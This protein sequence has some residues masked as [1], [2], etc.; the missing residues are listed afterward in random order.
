MLFVPYLIRLPPVQQERSYP[1]MS[2]D[3]QQPPRRPR[4]G[5][6]PFNFDRIANVL[7]KM[8]QKQYGAGPVFYGPADVQ[9]PEDEEFID[10]EDTD[11]KR[12]E[13]NG[14]QKGPLKENPVLV[15]GGTGRTGLWTVLGLVNAGINVRVFTR[16]KK[17]AE[18]LFGPDGSNVDVFEGDMRKDVENGL[19]EALKGCWGVVMCAAGRWGQLDA[20]E[21]KCVERLVKLGDIAGVERIVLVSS[22]GCQSITRGFD[23]EWLRAKYG[24]EKSVQLGKMKHC[25]VRA[26]RLSDSAGGKKQITLSSTDDGQRSS[27]TRIDLA[28]LLIQILV[29]DWKVKSE[30]LSNHT[31]ANFGN[32]NMTIANGNGS[33]QANG[34]WQSEL[35]NLYDQSLQEQ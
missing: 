31:I 10:S 5:K 24:A 8:T 28:Q 9:Y 14:W 11:L 26:G 21:G 30:A 16:R 33:A 20:V 22:K 29:R 4:P 19:K 27:L 35:D 2:N 34:F 7:D 18:K 32:M 6:N 12:N 17:R 23:A 1:L 25:I 15:V 13:N 3:S